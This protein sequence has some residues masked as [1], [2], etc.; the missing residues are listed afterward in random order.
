ME[1]RETEVRGLI[2]FTVDTT[3]LVNVGRKTLA[4]LLD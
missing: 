3:Q 4:G 1:E 2:G